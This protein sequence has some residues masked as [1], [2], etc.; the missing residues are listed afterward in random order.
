MT[1]KTMIEHVIEH[2]AGYLCTLGLVICLVR[3]WVY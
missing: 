1:A 2:A 3:F